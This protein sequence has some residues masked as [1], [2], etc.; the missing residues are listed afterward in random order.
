MMGVTTDQ[1]IAAVRNRLDTASYPYLIYYHGD[2]APILPDTP[3]D[4][5]YVVFNNEGSSLAAFGGGRGNNVYRNRAR[6]EIF[7]FAPLGMGAQYVN[8]LA[9]NVAARLR[10][11]RDE[12]ISCFQA[13]VIPVGPGSTLAVPGL[14]NDVNNYQCAIVEAILIFD[15]IG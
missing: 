5:A 12:T 15:L 4:W 2:D 1:A 11:Y 13:D 10:S 9:E 8:M 6:V 14:A 7:V 3:I